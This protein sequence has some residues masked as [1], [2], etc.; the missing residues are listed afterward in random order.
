M[1]RSVL[2]Y[3]ALLSLSAALSGCGVAERPQRP[4]WR[5]QYEQTCLQQKL[6]QVSAY[7]Q[8]APAIDGP[9]ICGMQKPFKVTALANGSVALRAPGTL[10]CPMVASMDRWINDVVQPIA[11]AR[12][13][14]PVA[15]IQS[16]GSYGCRPINHMRG[17]KLSEHSFGNAIDIGAFRLA[18]GREVKIVRDWTRGGE[19]ERAFLRELHAGACD[20]FT[21]VLGPGSDAMH[22]NHFHFDLAMHGN[23]SRGPRRVC[24]PNTPLQR[25][26]PKLDNLPDPPE[27]E[28]E[29]DIARR[30]QRNPSAV[31]YAAASPG[32]GMQANRLRA[33]PAPR[34]TIPSAPMPAPG[35]SAGSGVYGRLQPAAGA[36][37]QLP[38]SVAPGAGRMRDDGMFVAPG[39]LGD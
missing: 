7:V 28:P 26:P 1:V 12:F 32:I 3:I 37:I 17:A 30:M 25:I 2:P 38:G 35:D 36:P 5:N 33:M 14:Q 18:D 9:G 24:R 20:H 22:Y 4:A 39:E 34:G 27:L 8:P 11:R 21:T 6:V 15:E 29:I 23:T 13:G 31:G 16:A 10:A 19:Q